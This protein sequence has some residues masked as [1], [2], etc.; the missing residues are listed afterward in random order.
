MVINSLLTRYVTYYLLFLS[1]LSIEAPRLSHFVYTL[2]IS[3]SHL[4]SIDVL[5]SFRLFQIPENKVLE[6]IKELLS[7][8]NENKWNDNCPSIT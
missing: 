3:L 8:I 5:V 6:T 2:H 4:F 1:E 7:K